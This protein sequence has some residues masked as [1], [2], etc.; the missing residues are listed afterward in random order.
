MRYR[1]HYLLLMLEWDS[2]WLSW[3]ILNRDLECM[4]FEV[5][6]FDPRACR[7]QEQNAFIVDDHVMAEFSR[8]SLRRKSF[9]STPG[10]HA[11][12]LMP[13]LSKRAF[14]RP[15]L[16]RIITWEPTRQEPNLP[17]CLTNLALKSSSHQDPISRT[18]SWS[19]LTDGTSALS[20]GAPSSL[21]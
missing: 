10:R 9:N 8:K 21:D 20:R 5:R 13:L 18:K 14:S 12:C 15:Q 17:R 4:G 2:I 6:D 7:S 11:S 19:A 3:L 1:G 16:S